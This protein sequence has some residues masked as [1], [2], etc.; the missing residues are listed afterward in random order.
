MAAA[1]SAAMTLALLAPFLF[2]RGSAPAVAPAAVLQVWLR[3]PEE[4]VAAPSPR[5]G[6]RKAPAVPLPRRAQAVAPRAFEAPP[7]AAVAAE[8]PTAVDGRRAASAADA[9]PS[10]PLRLDA[11]VLRE[12]ARA[13]RSELD[14]LVQHDGA[15]SGA[16]PSAP[17][18]PLARDMARSARPA[19]LRPGG[20]LLSVFAIGYEI[21]AD[22]C[23]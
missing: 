15:A 6:A 9:A 14:R 22:K 13:S 16:A 7:A 20:S 21:L 10:A 18:S 8:A 17:E 4:P 5:P 23:R 12:A 3:A 1:A 2:G 11:R 19:C